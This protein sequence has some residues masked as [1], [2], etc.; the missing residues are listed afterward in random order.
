MILSKM[1][2]SII[3]NSKIELCNFVRKE[4]LNISCRKFFAI[5]ERAILYK[6]CRKTSF[7]ESV[8]NKI[9]DIDYRPATS[10]TR[11]FQQGD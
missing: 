1:L 3:L 11:S 7:E 5:L 4:A 8:F 6:P 2:F 9:N 10:L